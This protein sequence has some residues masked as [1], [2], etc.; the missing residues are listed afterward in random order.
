MTEIEKV[1]YT[2]KTHTSGGREGGVSRSSDGRLVVK[3]TSPGAPGNGTNPEQLFAAGWSACFISAMK[4]AAG[5]MNVD[6]PADLAIDAE[7]DVGTTHNAYGLAARLNASLPGMERE[8]A[9]RLV[10]ATDQLCPYSNATRG[11]IDVA[12][13][14]V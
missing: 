4:I 14:L 5:K 13:N 1:L 11:N 3:F 9:Q 8:V 12:I 6:L 10:E 7:V 2:A